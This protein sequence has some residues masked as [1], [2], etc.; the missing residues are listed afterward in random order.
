MRIKNLTIYNKTPEQFRVLKDE[1]EA[2]GFFTK[3]FSDKLIVFAIR[4]QKTDDKKKKRGGHSH[5]TGRR[6]QKSK[7]RG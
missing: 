7:E 1:Y 4:P 5:T 6:E 3:L 2:A